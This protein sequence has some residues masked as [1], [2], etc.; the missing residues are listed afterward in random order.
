MA[1]I[2]D[3]DR[4][5]IDWDA[6]GEAVDRP[7]AEART[8]VRRTVEDVPAKIREF[9]EYALVHKVVKVIPLDKSRPG[10]V[11]MA[12]EIVRQAKL[13]AD[14]RTPTLTV[15]ASVVEDYRIPGVDKAFP[16]AVTIV[17]RPKITRTRKANGETETVPSEPKTETTPVKATPTAG[18]AKR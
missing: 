5:E 9:V 8:T 4:P 7:V 1:R 15:G 13:Y 18:R 2:S 14:L 16:L 6:V 11:D 10:T 12:K 3:K 17:A